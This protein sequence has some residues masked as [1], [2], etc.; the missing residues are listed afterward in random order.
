V[1]DGVFSGCQRGAQ[2]SPSVCRFWTV[3]TWRRT[4]CCGF[5]GGAIVPLADPPDGA[6]SRTTHMTSALALVMRG[7]MTLLNARLSTGDIRTVDATVNWRR[8]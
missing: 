1:Q 4:T 6:L 2:S 7:T 3:R 8:H 5:E